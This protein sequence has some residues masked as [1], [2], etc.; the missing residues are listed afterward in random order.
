[1][2]THRKEC[3][4]IS[5]GWAVLLLIFRLFFDRNLKLTT[6]YNYEKN[7][8]LIFADL[9]ADFRSYWNRHNAQT[10]FPPGVS[11]WVIPVNGLYRGE[12][13]S[14]N[15][16]IKRNIDPDSIVR[17]DF[18]FGQ[19]GL[20]GRVVIDNFRLVKSS[21]PEDIWAFDHLLCYVR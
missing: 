3:A 9:D 7:S 17:L 15:N 18:G 5:D 1:M 16:D 21:R 2:L 6:T 13:G 8:P 14:R 20:S 12:A 4:N 19:R 11:Q 10:T